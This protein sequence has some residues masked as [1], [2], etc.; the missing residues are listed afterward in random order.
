MLRKIAL[1]T[2]IVFILVGIMGLIPGLTPDGKLLGIFLVHGGLL[3]GGENV[4][5]LLSG[6]AAL[7]ASQ[8]R[9]WSRLFFK[10]IGVVYALVTILGFLVGTGSILGLVHVN[11]ADNFLHLVFTFAFLYLGFA[12]KAGHESARV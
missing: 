9:D 2:G 11:P 7:V 6:V 8:R 10:I 5:H 1:V 4:V 3:G 12:S